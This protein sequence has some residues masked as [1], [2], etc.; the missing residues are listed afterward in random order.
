MRGSPDG[1]LSSLEN[2]RDSVNRQPFPY[3]LVLEICSAS[4]HRPCYEQSGNASTA[5]S[6]DSTGARRSVGGRNRFRSEPRI[7]FIG[8]PACLWRRSVSG[9]P[10]NSA[11]KA[12]AD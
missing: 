6:L 12:R 8:G 3:E 7:L 10:E 4:H 2:G 5:S 9:T 1:G 11:Q